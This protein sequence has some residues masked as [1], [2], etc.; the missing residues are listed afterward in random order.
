M[1]TFWRNLNNQMQTHHTNTHGILLLSTAEWYQTTWEYSAVPIPNAT[2]VTGSQ[3]V[4]LAS[5]LTPWTK[6]G[7][8]ERDVAWRYMPT[9]S[10]LSISSLSRLREWTQNTTSGERNVRAA[11]FHQNDCSQRRVDKIQLTSKPIHFEVLSTDDKSLKDQCY[12]GHICLKL[13]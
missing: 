5:V 12:N 7:E 2:S 4:E 9:K 6:I 1:L 10:W 13:I 8:Q 3:L 11:L